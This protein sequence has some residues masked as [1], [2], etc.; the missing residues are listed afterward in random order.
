MFKENVLIL[1]WYTGSA[2]PKCF[3]YI[4]VKKKKGEKALDLK[5]NT[6][7]PDEEKDKKKRKIH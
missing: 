2:A 7:D 6:F 1:R 3:A 4:G 5:E